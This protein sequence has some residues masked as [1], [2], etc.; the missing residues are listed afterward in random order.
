M[1][2]STVGNGRNVRDVSDV[3]RSLCKHAACD[4]HDRKARQMGMMGMICIMGMIA[5]H[6]CFV[7]I[8]AKRYP[9]TNRWHERLPCHSCGWFARSELFTA[10]DVSFGL[11]RL[12][13]G[14]Y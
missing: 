7:G 6:T 8:Q 4:G 11:L 13:A 12:Y 14:K 3:A 9:R 10:G 2:S 1:M 5:E